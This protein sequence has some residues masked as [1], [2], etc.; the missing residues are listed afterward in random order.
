LPYYLF[1]PQISLPLFLSIIEDYGHKHSLCEIIFDSIIFNF[2]H[3]PQIIFGKVEKLERRSEI[4]RG[5][6]GRRAK[7]FPLLQILK[8]GSFVSSSFYRQ[9][10]EE[11]EAEPWVSY[12][13]PPL[14]SSHTH[15][16]CLSSSISLSPSIS[17]SLSIYLSL[18]LL[19]FYQ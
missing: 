14:S 4:G 13:S 9:R 10:G 15:S 12:P 16:L 1:T 3:S 17:L 2:L 18:S 7:G 11:E 19:G 6:E 8:V 5:R